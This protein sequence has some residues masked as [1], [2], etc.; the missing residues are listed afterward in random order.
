MMK[1]NNSK[2]TISIIP[3]SIGVVAFAFLICLAVGAWTEPSV[4]PPGE[5]VPAPL[6][7]GLCSDTQILQ[8][9][10]GYNWNCVPMPSGSGSGEVG[11]YDCEDCDARFVNTSG[12]DTINGSLTVKGDVDGLNA[13]I[14]QDYLFVKGNAAETGAVYIAG[15][16]IKMYTNGKER[17]SIDSSGNIKI[18]NGKLVLPHIPNCACLATNSNGEIICSTGMT[19]PCD[20]L[21]CLDKC[22]G[23]VLFHNGDCSEGECIYTDME[24]CD[25]GCSNNKCNLSPAD[26][27]EGV[28]CN[29]F[30]QSATLLKYNGV[31]SGGACQ[32]QSKTCN[33][34]CSNNQCNSDP[35]LLPIGA[36]CSNNSQCESGYCHN[37]VCAELPG[38]KKSLGESCSATS[39]CQ[40]GYCVDGVCCENSCSDSRKDCQTCGAL[41]NKGAGHCGYVKSSSADPG[42]DCSQG[43]TASNGCES[44]NCS[45]INYSCGIVASGQDGGCPACKT[46][47]GIN[48]SCKNYPNNVRDTRGA[49]ICQGCKYC[50]SGMCKDIP[51]FTDPFNEC[52][53]IGCNTG[54]CGRGGECNWY[55]SGEGNCSVCKTCDGA[56]S[57]SCKY[58]GAGQKDD[59]GNETCATAHKRCEGSGGCSAPTSANQTSC[60]NLGSSNCS[61]YCPGWCAGE[62]T[63]ESCIVPS[64]RVYSNNSC[65][66]TGS[67]VFSGSCNQ[68]GGGC[69]CY[70][71]KYQYPY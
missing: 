47:D 40:S 52:E 37:G 3:L 62:S 56:T 9:A 7:V 38:D 10:D 69:K 66:G 50:V 58:F 22:M 39:E 17:L 51:S 44:D 54:D 63:C 43:T 49:E 1:K 4:A 60:L 20:G 46:C 15:N 57:T 64:M 59:Q 11:D 6:H 31:C 2:N 21:T 14:G 23:E 8:K 28:V 65:S 13:L 48:A 32:Y 70:Y 16:G 42:N 25:Y 55:V 45:G 18:L 68:S 19:N 67:G 30:C 36:A 26:P 34:G 71:V 12:G 24:L 35:G 27:C 29:Q 33:Y 41:S 61:G 5:N 53:P